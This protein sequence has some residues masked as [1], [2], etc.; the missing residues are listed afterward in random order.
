M[1]EIYALIEQKIREAGYQR[2]V[3]GRE[4]YDEINDEIDGK[5]NGTYL[6]MCKK[7]EDVFFEYKIDVMEEAFNLSSITINEK[8]QKIY[9]DLDA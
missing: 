2:E 1:E 6:F 8:G 3:S 7:T 5:E 9:V 4:I